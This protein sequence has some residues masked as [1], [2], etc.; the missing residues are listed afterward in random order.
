MTGK[1]D[2]NLT[3]VRDERTGAN[4]V[5][6]PGPSTT[7]ATNWTRSTNAASRSLH[8][9]AA[10]QLGLRLEQ[11]KIPVDVLVVD[12]QGEKAPKDN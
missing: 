4:I 3:F 7:A 6:N 10:E 8:R 9:D 2:F 12:W 5:G 1:Y 11:K